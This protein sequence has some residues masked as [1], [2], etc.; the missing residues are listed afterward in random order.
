MLAA[1]SL[2]ESTLAICVDLGAIF[3]SMELSRSK[4]LITGLH[5]DRVMQRAQTLDPPNTVDRAMR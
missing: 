1:T 2:S 5:P 4:W 3:L